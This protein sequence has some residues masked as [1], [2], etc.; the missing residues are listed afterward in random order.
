VVW[1]TQVL[2]QLVATGVPSRSEITD[3]A[4]ADR[5]DC[6]MLNKGPFQVL[7]VET[8]HE[9]LVRTAGRHRGPTELFPLLPW[10][11]GT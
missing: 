6:V 1:A 10:D 7:G 8:L 2:D 5:A 9:L 11:S 3:A 4:V